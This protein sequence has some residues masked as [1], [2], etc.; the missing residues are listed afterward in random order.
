MQ[1]G[2]PV[3][4][5]MRSAAQP[6]VMEVNLSSFLP[7]NTEVFFFL[8]IHLQFF[9]IGVPFPPSPGKC[10]HIVPGPPLSMMVLK[11]EALE[12]KKRYPKVCETR[13]GCKSQS[14]VSSSV[15]WQ[16]ARVPRIPSGMLLSS[17]TCDRSVVAVKGLLSS[18]TGRA[19]YRVC[20]MRKELDTETTRK[21]EGSEGQA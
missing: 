13:S 7:Q 17:G 1:T 3:C 20:R 9:R 18:K 6:Y 2:A 11:S 19:E 16:M 10:L 14:R 5:Q 8:L 4:L 15:A 12:K 21:R